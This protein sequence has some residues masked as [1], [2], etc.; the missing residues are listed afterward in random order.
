MFLIVFLYD[1]IVFTMSLR[2]NVDVRYKLIHSSPWL[3]KVL[4][5]D[6]YSTIAASTGLPCEVA[7]RV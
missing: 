2:V 4:L 7:G 3:S 6:H 1:D 5:P